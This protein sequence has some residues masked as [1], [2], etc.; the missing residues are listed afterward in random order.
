MRN[1]IKEI[2]IASTV[3]M[4]AQVFSGSTNSGFQTKGFIWSGEG[5][6]CWYKQHEEKSGYFSNG[7]ISGNIGILTFDKSNCMSEDSMGLGHMLNKKMINNIISKWYSHS[8]AKFK[9]KERELYDSS[10]FQEKGKCMQS[11]TYEQIGITIDYL[12]GGDGGISTVYHGASV[13]G[14]TNK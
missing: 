6:K 13:G 12:L 7:G 9:T 14:C 5:K 4:S 2:L 3:L 10:V 11:R 8:D 1:T